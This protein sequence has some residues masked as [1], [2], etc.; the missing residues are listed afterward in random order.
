MD[1]DTAILKAYQNGKY[2]H[3]MQ[4]LMKQYGDDLYRFI[5]S[6]LKNEDDAQ[7]LIQS[8]FIIYYKQLGTYRGDAPLRSWL[9]KV[10]KHAAFSFMEKAAYQ[11]AKSDIPHEEKSYSEAEPAIEI[12]DYVRRLEAD[13]AVPLTMYYFMNCNYEEISKI[14]ELPLNSLKTRIR[15]G[16]LALYELLKKEGIHYEDL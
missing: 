4:L 7:D 3:S 8:V 12:R 11:M 14:L 5:R 13:L 16:K 1:S 2:Q 10:A 6:Y 9:F 15:R